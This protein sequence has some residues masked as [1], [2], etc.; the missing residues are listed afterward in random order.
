MI[1]VLDEVGEVPVEE[2]ILGSFYPFYI[3]VPLAPQIPI[4]KLGTTFIPCT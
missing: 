1:H 2:A 4:E 3:I